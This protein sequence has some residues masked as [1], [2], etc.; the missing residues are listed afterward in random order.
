LSWNWV[1]GSLDVTDEAS[2]T[3]AVAAIEDGIDC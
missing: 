2:M 3:A 1:R